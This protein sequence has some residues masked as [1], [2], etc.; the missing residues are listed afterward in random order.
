MAE[1]ALMITKTLKIENKINVYDAKHHS[2]RTS[3]FNTKS[4]LILIFELLL[5]I[6][7]IVVAIH[8]F[9]SNFSSFFDDTD[10]DSMRVKNECKN[11]RFMTHVE[12]LNTTSLCYNLFIIEDKPQK[13]AVCLIS[14]PSTFYDALNSC[15]SHN[16]TLLKITN[17]KLQEKI[18]KKSE[19]IFGIGKG[20]SIWIDGKWSAEK[21]KWITYFDKIEL[22]VSVPIEVEDFCL[23]IASPVGRKFEFSSFP[24]DRKF[25]FYCQLL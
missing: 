15:L 1:D 14:Q 2:H 25:Y 10:N 19:D 4:L 5:F 13:S 24:C 18:F 20:S 7:I 9:S 3:S 17:E 6:V 12:K 21:Q 11:Q 22:N 16:M 23:K 8:F